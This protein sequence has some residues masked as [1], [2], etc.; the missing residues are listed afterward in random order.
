MV[1]KNYCEELSELLAEELSFCRE[2]EEHSMNLR[3]SLVQ[4]DIDRISGSLEAQEIVFSKLSSI[5]TRKEKLLRA[6]SLVYGPVPMPPTIEQLED[7]MVKNGVGAATG[8]S[9]RFKEVLPR[10][11]KINKTNSVLVKDSLSKSEMI[12]SLINRERKDSVYTRNGTFV[13]HGNGPRP[14]MIDHKG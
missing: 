13:R 6:I 8:I 11:L 7:L 12:I 1:K 9:A 10:I 2:M 5:E 14:S 3:E 4:D